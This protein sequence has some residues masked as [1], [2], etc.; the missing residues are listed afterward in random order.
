MQGFDPKSLDRFTQAALHPELTTS[1]REIRDAFVREYL[2]DY[3]E[4]EA[5]IRIGFMASFAKDYAG[6]FMSEPYV[7][8]KIK[9]REATLG[10]E[11]DDDRRKLQ[12]LAGLRREANYRGSGASHS[13]R[14]NALTNLAKLYGMEPPTKTQAE[15]KVTSPVQ[16]YLPHNGRDPVVPATE[17]A[18]TK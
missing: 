6:K 4:T 2:E 8:Q 15:V 3:N 11:T 17:P 18:E 16:F 9:E 10:I 7:L 12:I 1:E 13:A 14:V 5:T